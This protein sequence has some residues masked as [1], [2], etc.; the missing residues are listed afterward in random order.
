VIVGEGCAGD[1]EAFH[2]FRPQ[3]AFD[4]V[5]LAGRFRGPFTGMLRAKVRANNTIAENALSPWISLM[6]PHAN[7]RRARAEAGTNNHPR[8]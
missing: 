2:L 8:A 3:Q 6:R 1:A 5:S 4:R 7:R